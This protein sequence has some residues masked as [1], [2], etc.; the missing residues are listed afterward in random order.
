[1]G[2]T[3]E[4]DEVDLQRSVKAREFVE[5][6]WNNPKARRKLLEAQKEVK[7][8]DP[9]VKELDR[10]DPIEDRFA[11]LT[12]QNDELRKEI[13]DD[14]AKREQDDKLSQLKRQRADGIAQLRRDRW[15]D[16]GIKGVE[17]IMEEKGILDPLDAAAIFEK[18][19][20]P[21]DPILPGG[22]GSWNFLEPAPAE[23]DDLK[24]LIETKGEN[25]FL[26][27]KMAREALMEVRGPTQRR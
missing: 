14:K 25:N 5:T 4:V 1:M 10:P 6:I 7:P 15:T 11:A 23:S 16:E 19:H 18:A 9:M 27:D 20:P 2:K 8:D 13:A 24:K 22:S 3:V 17:A 21:Q 26:L 12:K